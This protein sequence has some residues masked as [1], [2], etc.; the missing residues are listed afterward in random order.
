MEAEE[1]AIWSTKLNSWWGQTSTYT[2][3]FKQAK[4]FTRD[5]AIAFCKARFNGQLGEGTTVIPV[6]T[7]MMQ[8]IEGK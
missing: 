5:K 3:D 2:S 4:L 6:D 8:E 1:Y 7:R